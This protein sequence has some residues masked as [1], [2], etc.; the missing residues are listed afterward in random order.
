MTTAAES[1]KEGPFG[2]SRMLAV[3]EDLPADFFE[4]LEEH[5]EDFDEVPELPKGQVELAFTPEA[6]QSAGCVWSYSLEPDSHLSVLY[7]S[8][9]VFAFLPAASRQPRPKTEGGGPVKRFLTAR[10][11]CLFATSWFARTEGK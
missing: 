8:H 1:K 10:Q 11:K 2:P 9:D 3:H 6:Q 4:L 5:T 7:F